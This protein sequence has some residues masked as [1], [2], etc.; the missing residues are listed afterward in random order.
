ML[1]LWAWRAEA[2]EDLAVLPALALVAAPVIAVLNGLEVFDDYRALLERAEGVPAPVTPQVFFG[3]AIA[4]TL[5]AAARSWWGGRWPV[6]WAFGAALM[7]PAI[8]AALEIFWTPAAFIG[9]YRWAIM[10]MVGAALTTAL[11]VAF[12]RRDGDAGLRAGY[13]ALA[14]IGLITF[15]LSILLSHSALTLAFAVMTVG[16]AALDR[17]FA[18]PALGLAVQAGAAA[19][20]YRLVIDPGLGV[21]IDG[22]M[23]ETLLSYGGAT[24]A[25][26]ACIWLLKPLDRPR[27]KLVAESAA[28]SFAALFATALI[29]QVARALGQD[30]FD[31][32]GYVG[33]MASVWLISAANQ[34]W[35]T[36]APSRANPVRII[37]AT[38]Y[39]AIALLLL[40]VNVTVL[41]PLGGR[42]FGYGVVGPPFLNSMLPG[43][44][45]PA[46]IMGLV[47]QRFTFLKRGLRISIGTG[48]AALGALW[49]FLAIRHF[50]RGA[51]IASSTYTAPELYSYTIVLILV[52]VG[53]IFRSF[54]RRS[55]FL[56][57]AGLAV[58]LAAVA[59]V[60]FI[61]ISGLG[62]LFRI[63][64]LLALGLS[65]A[66]LAAFD[67]WAQNRFG[68]P[69]EPPADPPKDSPKDPEE[70]PNAKPPPS[71]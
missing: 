46:V 61:D 30:S 16:A 1:A 42:I 4:A 22:T 34:L 19:L 68:P 47:A 53:L 38:V 71:S 60:F 58:I 14:A 17:R 24:A 57:R 7:V 51:A 28:W 21:A 25:M 32:H 27:T 5:I 11:T 37:L 15:S 65:L 23:L 33:L 55:Q 67:R 12:A 45:L 63:F 66:G 3:F 36:K 49:L 48:A 8:V 70:A 13:F 39:G 35:R 26:A 6:Y 29:L 64:S 40:A 59:K 9:T 41:N 10:A 31:G 18:M 54:T 52:G 56:R 44:L 62:G 43:Y 20:T 50:W 69:E 2:L